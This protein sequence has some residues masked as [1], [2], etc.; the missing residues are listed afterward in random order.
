[1]LIAVGT[2][3]YG[4]ICHGHAVEVVGHVL[5]FLNFSFAP[6]D[7]QRDHLLVAFEKKQLALVVFLN[8][9]VDFCY[10]TDVV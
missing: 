7:G 8:S 1:M 3:E 5:N 6:R 10:V 2:E 4:E 9:F